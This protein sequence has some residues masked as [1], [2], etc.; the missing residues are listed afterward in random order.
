MELI[1]FYSDILVIISGHFKSVSF[2]HKM[3]FDLPRSGIMYFFVLFN[4]NQ[5]SVKVLSYDSSKL[6]VFPVLLH[7]GD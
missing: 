4:D 7:C 6:Y 5:G 1:I 2:L 3:Y